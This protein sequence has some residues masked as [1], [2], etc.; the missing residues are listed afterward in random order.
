MYYAIPGKIIKLDRREERDYLPEIECSYDASVDI[1]GVKST[2]NVSYIDNPKCGDY[3]V[4][5]GGYAIKRI[6]REYYEYLC[7]LYQDWMEEC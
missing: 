5:H 3:V 1:F 2:I 6:S 7:S 4:I